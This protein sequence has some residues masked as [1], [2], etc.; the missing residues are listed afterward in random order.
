MYSHTARERRRCMA[1]TKAGTPCRGWA[2]WQDP[3]QRC[4]SHG[5]RRRQRKRESYTTV[6]TPCTCVAYAWPHRPAGGLCRWPDPPKYRCTIP[7]ST[8]SYGHQHRRALR[9]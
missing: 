4:G 5:G 2:V 9:W 6:Y 1:V 3:L 7:A 8:H